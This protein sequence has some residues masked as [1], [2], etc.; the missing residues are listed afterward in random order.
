V[1]TLEIL[2]TPRKKNKQVR[3]IDISFL[4]FFTNHF[5]FQGRKNPK[6]FFFFQEIKFYWSFAKQISKIGGSM[7][8]GG[9]HYKRNFPFGAPTKNLAKSLMGQLASPPNLPPP[10]NWPIMVRARF[11]IGPPKGKSLCLGNPPLIDPPLLTHWASLGQLGGGGK[12]GQVGGLQFWTIASFGV[13]FLSLKGGNFGEIVKWFT[14][15][16][17]GVWEFLS[18]FYIEIIE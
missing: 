15:N 6:T 13:A 5:S 10:P 1:E 17:I 18:I 8:W 3:N 7:R 9:T 11:L 14:L 12:G 4:G 2:K 16:I